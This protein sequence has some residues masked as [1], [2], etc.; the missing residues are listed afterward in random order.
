MDFILIFLRHYLFRLTGSFIRFFVSALI[1]MFK[2]EDVKKISTF[3]DY[4]KNP[5]NEF[6]DIVISVFLLVILIYM[7]FRV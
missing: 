6:I 1:S 7:F 5:E 2:K 4:N 3:R